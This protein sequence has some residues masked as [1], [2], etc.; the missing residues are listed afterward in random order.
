MSDREH[1]EL[2]SN[3][4]SDGSGD[5]DL[6][7]PDAKKKFV[8]TEELMKL[9][10]SASL[11]PLSCRSIV[12]KLPIPVCDPAHPPKLDEAVS[13]L[14]PKSARSHDKF[15]SRLQKYTLN[16]M[17]RP[18]S[19]A[20]GLI[21]TINSSLS[22]LGNA[23]AHFNVERRKALMKHLNR[24]LRLLPEGEFPCRGDKIFGEDFA[25]TMADNIHAFKEYNTRT[26]FFSG[27]G[28]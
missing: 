20:H 25:K 12:N 3:S 23:S 14:V 19:M 1:A 18:I 15:L 28:D 4:D 7:E 27:S 26:C 13:A 9:L 22:L 21:L 17:A 6:N 24:D 11:K 10:H 16:A 2:L 5:E 8:P